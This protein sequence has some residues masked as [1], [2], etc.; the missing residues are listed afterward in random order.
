M[1]RLLLPFAVKTT[2][3]VLVE[4]KIT[5]IVKAGVDHVFAVERI[6]PSPVDHAGLA[7]V[8]YHRV[9][10]VELLDQRRKRITGFTPNTGNLFVQVAAVGVLLTDALWMR[11]DEVFD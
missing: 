10:L 3:D 2:F 8:V 4:V 1:S 9:L 11:V 6:V 7:V 5:E